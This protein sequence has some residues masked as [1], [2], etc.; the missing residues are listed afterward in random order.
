MAANIVT[1]NSN[2]VYDFALSRSKIPFEKTRRVHHPDVPAPL[3]LACSGD[4]QKDE[5]K[6][7]SDSVNKNQ[8]MR[9]RRIRLEF[10]QNLLW[11]LMF[12]HYSDTH[13]SRRKYAPTILRQKHF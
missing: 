4:F 8:L 13:L 12:G 11:A 3:L 1:E 10:F 9:R 5:P 6:T 2:L 7:L